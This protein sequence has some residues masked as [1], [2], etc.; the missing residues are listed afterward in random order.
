MDLILLDNG[1]DYLVKIPG[2]Q[3]PFRLA[4]L[5]AYRRASS[6]G[7]KEME[8]GWLLDWLGERSLGLL[9]MKAWYDDRNARYAEVILSEHGTLSAYAEALAQKTVDVIRLLQ[10]TTAAEINPRHCIPSD[11]SNHIDQRRPLLLLYVIKSRD[12]M[13]L[14]PLRTAVYSAVVNQLQ[15]YGIHY[16]LNMD[17]V[18]VLDDQSFLRHW[19]SFTVE[20]RETHF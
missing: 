1:F 14:Q 4:N 16:A 8:A 20:V 13:L 3:R 6:I 15:R 9:E 12:V 7:Y 17:Q 18:L 10:P 2:R 11:I 19:R 5:P